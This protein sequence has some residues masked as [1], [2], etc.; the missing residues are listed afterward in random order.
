MRK[1]YAV[2]GL[3]SFG[4]SVALTLE[5]MGG[6]VMVMDSSYEK[7]QEVA[8]L[9]S[10][11]VQA[12]AAD[13]DALQVLGTRNLDVV[14]VAIGENLEASIMAVMVA[15]EM[16][17]PYILAKAKDKLQARIL[18]KIGADTVVLP[19][20]DTGVR[21]A[22]NLM[23]VTF[24]DWIELSSDFSMVE[25]K[26]PSGWIG[27]SLTELRVR[28]NYDINVVG[29]IENDRIFVSVDPNEPLPSDAVMI[30]IG[31]NRNLE[32]LNREE[33]EKE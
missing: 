16:G 10:Y 17:I 20:H 11:A 13:P 21:V 6:E 30:L 26:V 12:D 9:V 5:K 3:G 14:V 18:K 19:E 25:T 15:R 22:K 2:L 7:V 4:M 32:L 23:N 24:M 28:E 29:M 27:K 8:D 1:Q 31:A 33:E